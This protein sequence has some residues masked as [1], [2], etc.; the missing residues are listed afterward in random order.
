MA[1]L[2]L[3]GSGLKSIGTASRLEIRPASSLEAFTC[4]VVLLI[5]ITRILEERTIYLS[6]LNVELLVCSMTP[7]KHDYFSLFNSR[8]LSVFSVHFTFGTPHSTCRSMSGLVRAS[9]ACN[10]GWLGVA[11]SCGN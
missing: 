3:F 8:P 4:C 5:F 11:F 9:A 2:T 6:V 10:T 1:A 7:T